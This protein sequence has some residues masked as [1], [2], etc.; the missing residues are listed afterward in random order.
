MKNNLKHDYFLLAHVDS[1]NVLFNKSVDLGFEFKNEIDAWSK[2]AFKFRGGRKSG[3]I[4]A[5][6][7][8]NPLV[9]SVRERIE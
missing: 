2:I 4:Y 8:L 1:E 5:R 6:R 3:N 7:D 9:Y